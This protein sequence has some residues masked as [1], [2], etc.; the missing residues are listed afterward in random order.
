MIRIRSSTIEGMALAAALITPSLMADSVDLYVGPYFYSPGGE[1]TAV[2]TPNYNGNYSPSALASVTDPYNNSV[3]QGFETFCV[4]S[5]V[6]FTPYNWGNATPYNLSISLSSIGVPDA[7]ALSEGTAYLYSQFAQGTLSGYDFNTG[8]DPTDA[9]IRTQDAG[10]LQAAIWALQGGQT[11]GGFP[12]GT[13]GNPYY[14]DAVGY[15][16]ANNVTTA[17]TLATDFGTEIMNLTDAN[18]G[19]AQNQ[20]IYLGST[21]PPTSSVADSGTT[22]ALMAMS[23]AGLAY[24]SRKSGAAQPTPR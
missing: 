24:F 1:F 14:A 3:V 6:D 21:P 11:Y 8:N 18:G 19:P 5:D 12:S 23:L 10:E 20:L 22:S 13:V 16:G 7:F 2:T 4:Q 15:L 9:A 17:A